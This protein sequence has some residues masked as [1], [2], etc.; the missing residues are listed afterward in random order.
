MYSLV[1]VVHMQA[2]NVGGKQAC[3][4]ELAHAGTCNFGHRVV[5]DVLLCLCMMSLWHHY[6]PCNCSLV[7]K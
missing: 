4:H 1:A 5:L 7:R 2:G 6:M 3:W